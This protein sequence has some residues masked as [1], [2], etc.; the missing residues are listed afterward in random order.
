MFHGVG[1]VS[2]QRASPPRLPCAARQARP[3]WATRPADAPNS[4]E[5][6]GARGVRSVSGEHRDYKRPK[7]IHITDAIP[8]TAT[9]KVQRRVVAQ[10]FAPKA[11]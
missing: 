4:T 2:A 3:E 5:Q 11:S 6:T 10:V 8:R 9:G 7:R 1:V